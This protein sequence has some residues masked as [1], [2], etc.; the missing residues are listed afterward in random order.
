MKIFPVWDVFQGPDL[1]QF[2]DL[3]ETMPKCIIAE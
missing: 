1:G 2:M 3:D